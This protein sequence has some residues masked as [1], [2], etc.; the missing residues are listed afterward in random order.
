MNRN[1]Q[2][3]FVQ[4]ALYAD[5]ITGLMSKHELCFTP[6]DVA[7]R[8]PVH[9]RHLHNQLRTLRR[10]QRQLIYRREPRDFS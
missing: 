7:S 2:E 3:Q 9:Y 4:L 10:R 6:I 5:R 8:L 1:R